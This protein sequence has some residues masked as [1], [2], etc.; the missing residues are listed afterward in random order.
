M[1]KRKEILTAALKALLAGV[2]TSPFLK[3]PAT[4]IAEIA[5][6][7]KDKREALDTTLSNEQFE[8]LLTQSELSTT[9]A[10]IAAVGTEQTKKLVSELMRLSNEQIEALTKLTQSEFD[11]ISKKLDHIANTTDETN[12][13]VKELSEKIDKVFASTTTKDLASPVKKAVK[14][15]FIEIL[16]EHDIDESQWPEKLQEI[17]QQHQEL[18]AKW[19][20]VQSDDPAV[21]ALKT[22]ARQMIELGKYDKAD[23]FLQD[24]IEID[25]K[26]IQ[27]QQEK[28]EQRKLSMAQ[29]LAS[30]GKL[31]ETKLDYDNAIKLYKQA[32]D[33]IPPAQLGI[34]TTYINS[35]GTL[36]HTTA[37]YKK[38]EQFFRQALKVYET[39]L[40]PNHPNVAAVLSNLAGLLQDTNRLG[41]A[42][43]LM[44]R[45]LRINETS[46]GPN[47][48]NVARDLNNL[49]QLLQDMN[50]LDEA[51][52]LYRRALKITEASFGPDHPNV[53]TVLN[54]LAVLLQ[55][56]NCFDEAALLVRRALKIDETSFG[57][58]H[59]NV[60]IN[61]S[62]LAQLYKAT[63][64]LKEAEP[65]MRQALA[66]AE[67]SFGPDHPNVAKCLSNLAELL[68]AKNRLTEAEPL[69]R[70][71]LKIDHASFGPNHPNVAI[72]LNNLA[73]LLMATD[74]LDEAEALMERALLILLQFTRRTGH[75]HP[76]LE[77]AIYNYSELLKK[78]GHTK[79]EV[80]KRLKSLAP[81][82][83]PDENDNKN[84]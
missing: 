17:T 50:R 83:F 47:H 22:N 16:N 38:A 51:K 26:A 34:R 62:N 33:R 5:S 76:H 49:A 32:L 46:F 12:K 70:L 74:R 37:N 48:P 73:L 65:L 75:P 1:A 25:R 31:A 43:P 60:A 56:M 84:D 14:K 78:M 10:A 41:Q 18:L 39:S 57:P 40:G 13:V 7:S 66:I 52:S 77:D 58:D 27:A 64:R 82:M 72:G 61:L 71:A 6:L 63:N 9:N 68:R 67:T 79:K 3:I 81:E 23:H 20:T 42:K 44:R 69:Y 54:N 80:D 36:Y 59:P 4:F 29:L 45:A 24:A 8:V 30:R 19:Q 35:L 15:I 2:E 21:D 28:L 55:D 53:A 11:E